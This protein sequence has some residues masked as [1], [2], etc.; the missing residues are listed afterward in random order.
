MP[1]HNQRDNQ[2]IATDEDLENNDWLDDGETI[3]DIMC[4]MTCFAACLE[5]LGK[6]KPCEDCTESCK[7]QVLFPDYLECVHR[8]KIRPLGDASTYHRRTAKSRELLG[9]YFNVGQGYSDKI[10]DNS[11]LKSFLEDKLG[12]GYAVIASIG[13]HLI[14][15]QGFDSEN[16]IVD[17]PYGQLD[18]EKKIAGK[19][20]YNCSSCNPK[21]DSRNSSNSTKGN[22][23]K[24]KIIDAIKIITYYEF[25]Y[26]K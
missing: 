14:R 10:T 21:Y 23:N 7:D 24:W 13:G 16:I 25:Y 2:S 20:G 18:I 15:I 5:Y 9:N 22:N 12:N 11:S 19:N 8:D 1:Y 4:N 26:N 3:G 17:D 6:D